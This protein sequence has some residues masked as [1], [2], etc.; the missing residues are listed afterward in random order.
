MVRASGRRTQKRIK[1]KIQKIIGFAA[2]RALCR[3][4]LKS[5][6]ID[7]LRQ[8]FAIYIIFNLQTARAE[9]GVD[10]QAA[11]FA[12]ASATCTLLQVE[13]NASVA[14]NLLVACVDSRDPCVSCCQAAGSIYVQMKVSVESAVASESVAGRLSVGPQGSAQMYT[15]GR[16]SV[17]NL[18]D[19]LVGV[20]FQVQDTS[21]SKYAITTP[22]GAASTYTKASSPKAPWTSNDGNPSAHPRVS[23]ILKKSAASK[24]AVV[25]E[26]NRSMAALTNTNPNDSAKAVKD[27]I[28]AA[29]N[30]E[31]SKTLDPSI[32]IT[33]EQIL[34]L[35]KSVVVNFESLYRQMADDRIGVSRANVF[36]TISNR[37]RSETAQEKFLP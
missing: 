18:R 16:A 4:L 14:Q 36:K 26:C 25:A 21:E 10:G 6:L 24:A 13:S 7:M 8:L 28:S 31:L 27:A 2:I 29:A 1:L 22:T 35:R 19:S 32:G 20:G 33:M 11:A 34:A 5:E 37:Y 15:K 9:T 17:K 12:K 3:P 30:L 23:D